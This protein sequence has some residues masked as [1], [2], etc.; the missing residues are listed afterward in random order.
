V[1]TARQVLHFDTRFETLDPHGNKQRKR[2]DFT[3]CRNWDKD[4]LRNCTPLNC[5]ERYFGQRS[6]FNLETEQCEQVSD[7]SGPGEYYDVFSNEGVDPGNFVSVEELE[8]VKN[9]KFDSNFLDLQGPLLVSLVNLTSATYSILY[10]TKRGLLDS[11]SIKQLTFLGLQG[12]LLASF[13]DLTSAIY[14]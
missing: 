5:E 6:F 7:C 1:A 8:L 12:P 2:K 4:Y 9:G 14:R 3:D 10:E 13:V 11:M